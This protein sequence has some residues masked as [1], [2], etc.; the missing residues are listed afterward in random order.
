MKR[1][2]KILTLFER[3]VKGKWFHWGFLFLILVGSFG[4]RLYKINNPLG[5]WHS[6]RQADTASVSRIYLDYGINLLVPRYYDVS[7][8]QTGYYNP[9]GLRFVEFPIY[10]LF[11]V[12]AYKVF[13]R[14]SLEVWGRLISV[15]SAVSSTFFLYLIGKRFISEAW[16]TSS[17]NKWGGLAAAFFYAFIP[18]NIYFTRVILPE[19]MAVL[20]L[21]SSLWFFIVYVE[22]E[23]RFHLFLSALLLAL[24]MLLK[25]FVLFYFPVYL[26]L[27]FRKFGFGSL[28][29][30]VDIYFALALV[31]IPFCLWRV[32]MNQGYNQIGIPFFSWLFNG[33]GIRFRLAFWRWIFGERLGYLIL[34]IWGLP[35]FVFGILKKKN[36]PILMMAI[37]MFLYVS[38]LA[39][40]NVRHDYYQIITIPAIAMML[41]SGATYLWNNHGF[42]KW[43]ARGLVIFSIV[44]MLGIGL[45]Q[46]RGDY[47]VNHPE[48]FEAGAA[49]DKLVP[50]DAIV[51]APYNGDTAFLY[52]THRFGWPVVD[53]SFDEI[54]KLGASY[55]VSVNYDNDTNNLLS[56]YKAIE[57]N[58]EFVIID[59]HQP[60]SIT[61]AK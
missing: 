32:W 3:F 25:P 14:F 2:K 53:R 47:G 30:K 56:K 36:L 39:T 42:S 16:S 20:F 11:N 34:G 19:P 35:L 8:T 26:F 27:Y 43:I 23:T 29:K 1:F 59:L 46:V 4:V 13:P 41:A 5:D 37:G 15:F 7:P 52:Q 60:L 38:V 57:R 51:I 54:I 10:N 58:K 6:W 33:D 50:K 21:V 44:M 55:Y 12:A 22:K 31:I 18:F 28:W 40:G 49:V 24:A 17:V 9:R 45:Y 61:I 48:I